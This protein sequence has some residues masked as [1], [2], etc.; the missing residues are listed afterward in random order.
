[1]GGSVIFGSG[2]TMI[3]QASLEHPS[4]RGT[5]SLFVFGKNLVKLALVENNIFFG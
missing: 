5:T 4:A 2:L 1:M 3:G